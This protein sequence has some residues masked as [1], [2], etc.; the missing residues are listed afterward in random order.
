M[1]TLCFDFGNTLL[2]CAVFKNGRFEALEILPEGSGEAVRELL[3]KHSPQKTI[4]SSVIDH[5]IAVEQ[6]LAAASH[7]HKLS[8]DSKLPITSP[9]GK[10]H[11]IGADR[12]AMV[13]AAVNSH[14]KQH[15][16]V[17]GLGSC[18]TYNF[19]NK[20]HE[21]IGGSISPGME[22]RFKALEHY[23]AKLPLVK[24]DW[25]FPLLGYDT[26]TNIQ[27]GVLLG[28]AKEIDGIVEMYREKYSNFNV[29]LTGGDIGFFGSLLKNKIFADPY[30]I[31]KGL[32]AISEF[33][34]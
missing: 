9:V 25:N 28:M 13:V 31:Y 32:Y 34:Q 24:P 21:F 23:T 22:M 10:P 3:Q 15:N 11:T 4:L 30:L 16:L 6:E 33:N 1:T 20:Y 12:L 18:I 7:F 2:K 8:I 14:P 5:D 29:H 19:V 26:V 27:S 17:I